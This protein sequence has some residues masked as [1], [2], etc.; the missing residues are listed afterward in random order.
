MGSLWAGLVGIESAKGLLMTREGLTED[1]A[2]RKLQKTSIE[3]NGSIR[4]VAEAIIL[5]M[6]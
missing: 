3:K 5:M 1:Q 4:E 6:S 2:C